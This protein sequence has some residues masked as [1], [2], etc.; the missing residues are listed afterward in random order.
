M[1]SRQKEGSQ[2]FLKNQEIKKK[3]KWEETYMEEKGIFK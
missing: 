2:G 1:E 3:K